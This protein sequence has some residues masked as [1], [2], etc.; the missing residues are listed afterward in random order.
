MRQRRIVRQHGRLLSQSLVLDPELCDLPFHLSEFLFQVRKA[1]F[2]PLND[3][4]LIEDFPR[5][6][7]GP[8]GLSLPTP[9]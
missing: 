8:P 1:S 9:Q 7:A 6:F 5:L 4:L 2:L 3:A